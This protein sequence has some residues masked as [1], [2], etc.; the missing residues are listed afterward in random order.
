MQPN[1]NRRLQP[2]EF[3]H[4]ANHDP[5]LVALVAS[6]VALV[7]VLPRLQAPFAPI[8]VQSQGPTIERLERLSHLVVTRVCVADVLVGE[9]KGWGYGNCQTLCFG[10]RCKHSAVRSTMAQEPR[11]AS[12]WNETPR[13]Q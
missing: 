4:H 6:L 7:L 10:L 3:I 9:G 1:A 5:F 12:G 8:T 11:E 13:I 2:L